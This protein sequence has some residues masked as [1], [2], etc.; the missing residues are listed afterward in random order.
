MNKKFYITSSLPYI[1]SDP[2]LGFALELVQADV[3]ARYHQ[4]S[5]DDVIFNTG[6]D[7]H[8]L[9]VYRRAEEVGKSPKSYAD[10]YAEKFKNL[11]KT[12][13]ISITHFIRTT[14]ERHKRAAQVFWERCFK[15]GDIYKAK[16][17]IKYCVGCELEKT[18][19][20]LEN[21]CCPLH[22]NLPI[23][24]IEEENYFFKFSKYQKPLLKF[25]ENNPNFVIP[26]FRFNE[27]KR[28]VEGG[29]KDFS[30]SRLASK[31]PWGVSVPGDHDHVMFVWFD[32]LIN[33]ISTLGW[34]DDEKIFSEFWPGVQIAGKDNLRQQSAMWQAML[35]SAGLPNSRQI[36]I[37]GFITVDGQK[38]SKSLGNVIDPFH[39]VKKYGVDPVR[40]YLLREIPSHEDGDFSYQKF[41]A[42][43]NADLANNLGNLVSRVVALIEK[44]FNGSFAYSRKFVLKE[45]DDKVIDTWKKYNENINNFKL[46]IALESV[47]SLADFVNLYIDENKPWALSENPERLNV[48]ITNLV[49][50]LLNI[51]WFLK[52]FLPETSDRIFE[53][54]GADKNGNSWEEKPFKVKPQIL[55]PKI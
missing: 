18:E 43:Y 47:F 20:E 27:I 4:L 40:Y 11:A 35:M 15:N 45:V 10:E 26:D 36:L 52:P 49:V 29:L 50:I 53:V 54:L 12:L 16:Y 44:F 7:E 37:H 13:N 55:F 9:K 5:G 21:G 25:Y 32:A 51:A 39:L 3:I 48:V 46:Y 22:P 34:P 41:E 30:I 42:R 6:T 33:Y 31:L 1:N 38:I 28:F 17:K 14:D 24:E 19:S 2:H 8:G 23:E